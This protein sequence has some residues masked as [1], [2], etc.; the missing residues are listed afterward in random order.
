MASLLRQS[1]FVVDAGVSGMAGRAPPPLPVVARK[2]RC[3]SDISVPPHGY[4]FTQAS[5]MEQARLQTI[6]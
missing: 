3:S 4:M 6:L 5:K 1:P 2:A